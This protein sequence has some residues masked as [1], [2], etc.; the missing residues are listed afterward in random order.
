MGD[1]SVPSGLRNEDAALAFATSLQKLLDPI[2]R[3]KVEA[4]VIAHHALSDAEAKKASDARAL[5]K[6]HSDILEETKKISAQNKKDADILDQKQKEFYQ[7]SEAEKLKISAKW[8]EVNAAQEEAKALHTK[9]ENLINDVYSREEALRKDKEL[10]AQEVAK[11]SKEKEN[12]VEKQKDL[13]KQRVEIAALDSETKA[14]LE[15]LK[16]LNF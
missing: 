4:E 7:Q 8:S 1:I 9:A 14:K 12:V 15:K 13:D 10:F 11:L 6:Q 2:E 16:Q 5:I 3:K